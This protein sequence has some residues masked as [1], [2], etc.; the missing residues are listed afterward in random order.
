VAIVTL[1][2]ARATRR[3]ALAPIAT[4]GASALTC[5][6]A[7]VVDV[8]ATDMAATAIAPRLAQLFWVLVPRE[9]LIPSNELAVGLLIRLLAPVPWPAR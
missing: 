3:F 4:V 5:Q 2:L 7:A 1:T 9:A 6:T 8:H